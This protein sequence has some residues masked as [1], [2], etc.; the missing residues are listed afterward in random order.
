VND[1]QELVQALAIAN[2]DRARLRAALEKANREKTQAG[3]EQRETE[4]WLRH[5]E[6]SRSWK[7]TRPLRAGSVA[8]RSL[9]R[10]VSA[11]PGR[12]V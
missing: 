8:L 4:R 10:R 11:R 5:L 2:E 9:A 7:L 1:D 3:R 12:R 6:S